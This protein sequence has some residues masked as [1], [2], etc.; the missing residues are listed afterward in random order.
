MN[1]SLARL[2][3][4]SSLIVLA[5]TALLSA[6][7]AMAQAQ[8]PASAP[9]AD[10]GQPA[11]EEI[12]VT[13]SHIARN[14][15]EQQ[16]P[17]VAISA[18]QLQST[19]LTNLADNLNKLPQLGVPGISNFSSN[20]LDDNAGVSTINLR[21]LGEER[22]L[23]LID[24]RR[25][26][27]GN[28]V[29]QGAAAVDI[30]T[31]PTF[32]IDSVEIATNTGATYG[33]EAVAGVVNIKLKDHY[34][35]LLVNEQ[36]GLTTGQGD[37][38]TETFDVL[39][40]TSFADGNGHVMFGL[41]YQNAG[42]IYSKDRSFANTDLKIGPDGTPVYGPSSY[43][44]G[45]N[46][47]V[48]AGGGSL[49][50]INPAG[51]AVPYGP[52]QGFDR[53]PVRT[54]QIPTDDIKLVEKT[55]Y[56]ITPDITFH[57]D[58][59]F[60]RSTATSQLEPIAIDGDGSTTI[61][62]AGDYLKMPLNNYYAQQY[63]TAHGL[64][65]IDDGNGNFADWR[66][67]F[68]ELGD[69][70][71]DSTR[72]NWAVNTGFKGTID[73][74]FT[75]HADYTFSEMDNVQVGQSG[76]VVKLQQE[77]NTAVIGGQVVCA[78]A[79][80]RAAG[81][82]PID[83]FGYGKASAAAVNYIKDF[84]TYTDQNQ[85][86][87]LN[88][89]ITGPVY[90]LPWSGAGDVSLSAGFEYRTESGY[91]RGD[92][93]SSAGFNLDT[94]Q[95]PSGGS[96]SVEDYWAESKVALL[97]DLPGAKSLTLDGSFRY[98]D[99]SNSNVGGKESYSYGLTYAPV[100]DI[101]F[102]VTNGVAIR[103]PDLSDLYQG[104]GNSA[105]SVN[106]PCAAA[107]VAGAANKA[108]RIA[109][110]LAIPGMAA[111]MGANAGT[112]ANPNGM[113][114]ENIAQQQSEL[115]YVQGNPD[116]T[117]E[118]AQIL[119]YGVTFQ[120]RWVSGL[121]A[122]V[123]AFKYKIANAVQSIDLQTEANQCADTLAANFCD[124]VR[125]YTS[126][127]NEGLIQGVDQEPIN[128]GSLDERGIDVAINYGFALNDV[129]GGADGRLDFGWNY[130]Y[131]QQLEYTSI[132]GATTNQRGLFGAPKNKWNLNTTYS[133][134]NLEFNWQLRYVGSQSYDGGEGGPT[135]QPIVYNDISLHY[136]ITDQLTPYI[137]VN[138]LFNVQPPIV[139]E[140]YQQTGGGVTYAV[141]G[142]NTV[143]DVYDVIGRYIYFG[144]KYQMNWEEA[145]AEAAP[146]V[147]P[148]VVAPAPSVPKSYLV[149]FDFNKSDLTPQALTIVDTAAKNASATK[150]T[151]LTVTGHTDTVG[152]DAYNMRLSR[153]RAESV[154][155]ELEKDGI[156]SSEIEI[157]AKGKRDLLVPTKD[158]VREPQNR[159]VQIVFDGGPTS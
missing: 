42:A 9:A 143:P 95:P 83:F 89:D 119:T 21:N 45:G 76:N 120:P 38:R 4:G 137:G 98:S 151:Q 105:I 60:T 133:N 136:H 62:F 125:R 77:L 57:V 28:A 37:D 84:K 47:L 147:P 101:Q 135:F 100:E 142:T 140:E 15:L 156:A 116:L 134:D 130:E 66:R 39:T 70:G 5:G 74:T 22:T 112:A 10:A 126:G 14:T 44:L 109:H 114:V 68:N 97:K 108:V 92:P 96:Y 48:T 20:F 56:D 1:V 79:A 104:R 82:V 127:I 94:A 54:I 75:W 158:G 40:G 41:E 78:S 16:V 148:P 123:D 159:R 81:C 7:P 23:V 2:R 129:W 53:N 103:A 124:T 3:F 27:S 8:A 69:R 73:D 150:V 33:S 71:A 24:G 58:G 153:R 31:I 49:Y 154:A 30:S 19:G 91:N 35:G 88:L 115:S 106:D 149:F 12:V 144:V 107:Q 80:A 110:C 36:F 145:P 6:T 131:L 61:G 141:T 13:G 67:R 26:V 65:A 25:T 118:R 138:N 152:S 128:V 93:V 87:D 52:A 113:F 55:S 63:L 111:R 139:T 50:A 90:T 59:R 64:T 155:A 29:G 34:D 32:M 121:S 72:Y 18:T 146:Y 99:Y 51:N 132:N 86:N 11:M 157:V 17:V 102:R 122:T 46:F 85:E 117:N 43:T